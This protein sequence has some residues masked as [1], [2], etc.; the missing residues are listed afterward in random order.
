MKE[1]PDILW[2]E[3]IRKEDIAAVGGKG[4]SLG[5]MAVIGLPVPRAFVVTSHAFRRFLI[6]TGLED[7][8]FDNFEN[9]N[10]E[11]NHALEQAAQKAKEAVLRVSIPASLRE[12]IRLAYQ[13]MDEGPDDRRCQIKRD[14]RRPA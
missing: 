7:T 6:E 13:A 2:L 4:A 14:G 9:L 1:L 11:D 10:V 3:E 12:N 5:E 8:L